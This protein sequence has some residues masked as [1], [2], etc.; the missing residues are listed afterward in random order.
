MNELE[1]PIVLPLPSENRAL[2]LELALKTK[3]MLDVL[4]RATEPDGFPVFLEHIFSESKD[5]F[6]NQTF[7]GGEFTQEIARW[8]NGN[9]K[10]LRVSAKDH[11]KSMS[12]YAHIMWKILMLRFRKTNREI[13]YFSYKENMAAYHTAKIKT[14]IE[15]NPYFE[16]IIDLKDQAE[17]MLSYSW[18]GR[19][20][21]T[22]TPRGLLEFKRGIHCHDVYVDDPFQDPES[23]L[24]PKKINKINTTMKTQIIDMF[25]EECHIAGT[26]QTNHDFFF[27]KDFTSRFSVKILPAMVD[28]IKRV[29]L[30]PEWMSFEELEAK[31]KERGQRVFN[32]EYLCSPVYAENAYIEKEKLYSVV[33]PE[34]K[35]YSFDEWK[36][37]KHGDWDRV[38]GWDLGKKGHPAHFVVYEKRK[39]K[40]VQ[41]HDRWFDHIDY[42]DQ[43]AHIVQAIDVFGMYKV[44]YDSTR[45]ELEML[46]EAGSLPGEF[47]GV[48]FTFKAKHGMAAAIDQAISQKKIELLNE[49]RSL[50]QMLVVNNDLQAPATPEG[51]GDSFWSNGLS[52]MDILDEGVDISVV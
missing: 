45:G 34:N 32:Q 1:T 33:K 24:V 51:H 35:N 42:T 12:F 21:V 29:A 14:A 15:C 27:D 26:A 28:R 36:R 44:Y 10:T 41:I 31:E 40:R 37:E 23:K 9:S 8:L 4:R 20:K 11:F 43:L 39:D 22:V 16:G 5:I 30:W 18:D 19:K 25:Q 38:G 17:S 52:F 6:K 47:E 2:Q 49:P 48:H 7:T 13:Q 3:H 46:E 50:S